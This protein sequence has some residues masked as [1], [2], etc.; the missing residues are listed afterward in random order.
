MSLQSVEKGIEALKAGRR[1]EGVRLLRIALRDAQVTGALRAAALL[2]LAQVTD[3]PVEKR[4]YYNEAMAADPNNPQVRQIYEAYL[5]SQF[6]PPAPSPASS[7]GTYP[8]VPPIAAP[9]TLPGMGA[10][11]PSGSSSPFAPTQPTRS[12]GTGP[13]MPPTPQA[14]ISLHH[15]ATVIGGPNG[16]GT[17]FFAARDGLLATTRYVVGGHDRL[18]IELATGRQLDG[19]VVRSYPEYDLAFIYVEQQVT[20]LMPL[21]PLPNVAEEIFLTLVGPKGAIV[22]GR[23]RATKKVIKPG[24]FPTDFTELPDAGGSPVLDDRQHLVGM[25]TRNTSSTSNYLYGL[26]ISVIRSQVDLF[27]QEAMEG[28]RV[29][30]IHCGSYSRAFSSGGYY[31]EHCGGLHPNA[32]NV[33]RLQQDWMK[34]FYVETNRMPC[35]HCNAT[36]GFHKGMCLRCGR[37]ATGR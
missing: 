8:V 11:T 35:P 21:S 33:V 30:C 26:H 28:G 22:R 2:W 14:G 17:A 36:V 25:M 37:P 3:E 34:V 32:E 1:D 10:P 13:L 27:R 6:M 9:N 19:Y 24:W 15:V 16:P 18:V 7:T 5:A 20:D 23:R 31:C 12:P 29:Y 4:N